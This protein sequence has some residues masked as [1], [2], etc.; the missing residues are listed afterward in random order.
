MYQVRRTQSSVPV[1]PGLYTEDVELDH[2]LPSGTEIY[3]ILA[4]EQ[5]VAADQ[6]PGIINLLIISDHSQ[7]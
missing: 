3:T 1:H 7:Q 5:W 6:G 2:A 4:G